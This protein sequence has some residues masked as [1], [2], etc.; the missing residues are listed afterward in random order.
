MRPAPVINSLLRIVAPVFVVAACSTV[1]DPDESEV[2][3][4][5]TSFQGTSFQG[6]SFQGTSFQ[7]TSF[8]GTSFQG[9]TYG[10]VAVSSAAI[11]GTSISVW[12][13]NP[14]SEAY[15]W[16]QRFPN[17]ICRW[18]STRTLSSGCTAYDLSIS[19]SPL[20]GTNW[21][22]TFINSDGTT[23]AGSLRIG[24]S[25][26]D[27]GAVKPDTTSA[28]FPLN[29]SGTTGGMDHRASC[30][31]PDGCRINSD[32]WLYDIQLVD[33]DGQLT[34]FCPNGGTAFALAGTWDATGEFAASST[35]F[36]FACTGGT[37]AKCTR[38]G[39]RPWAN[40]RKTGAT[41]TTQRFPL[42][43]Y[44]QSCIRA[45]AAD[46]CGVGHSF[47]KDNTL[48]DIYDYQPHQ[49]F[50]VGFI[51]RTLSLF[52]DATAFVWE[53]TFDKHGA[54]QLDFIRYQELAGLPG[55]G[56][57]ESVCPGLFAAPTAPEPGEFHRPYTRDFDT[58]TTPGVSIDNTPVCSHSE[59]T[60]GKWLHPQCSHC[61]YEMW[62][63]PSYSYCVSVA[64]RWDLGCAMRARWCAVG[65]RMAAHGECS[66]STGLSLYDSACTLKVCS[67][68]S[69]SSCCNGLAGGW[70]SNCVN[71]ANARC[72]GGRES[73]MAGFCGTSII[74]PPT[75]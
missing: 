37:I 25:T 53:S 73:F 36:T 64:G 6:T 33:T 19:A 29:G 1:E 28:M 30:T 60:I 12:K 31:H 46:Y 14:K 44:H 32:L 26:A 67:D 71:A 42:A 48:V 72:T 43:D 40:A 58:W 2:Q 51:P 66:A 7:G 17:K 11:N 75:M 18:N 5:G 74:L 23:R 68:P 27:V 49:S 15:P 41:A 34:S 50:A 54:T 21:P 47:T 62:S 56:T 61:T 65:D 9:A 13:Q 57:L 69:L 52:Q 3:S 4:A 70:S 35:Q 63:D 8:Q 10:T 16:E 38:W 55:Y 59:A 20:A 45:A 22:A 39:Y 24:G